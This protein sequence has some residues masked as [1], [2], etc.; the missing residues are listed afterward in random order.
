MEAVHEEV[1][2]FGTLDY[3]GAV[4]HVGS[5]PYRYGAILVLGVSRLI[6]CSDEFGEVVYV[7]G[8]VCVGEEN[9]LA[10]GMAHAVGYCAAF[11]A[12]CDEGD[13]ADGVGGNIDGGS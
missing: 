8:A 1:A 2:E 9:V 13:E 7:R 12:I 5:G 11:S 4:D 6:C 3:G 10:A